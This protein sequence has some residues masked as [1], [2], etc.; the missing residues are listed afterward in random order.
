MAAPEYRPDTRLAELLDAWRNDICTAPIP[1]LVALD[2]AV[3]IV[4]E[5]LARAGTAP[6]AV[7]ARKAEEIS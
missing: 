1:E 2:V 4:R 5:E 3:A 7:P 6:D